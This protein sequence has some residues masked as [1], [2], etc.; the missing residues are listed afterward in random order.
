MKIRKLILLA[1][2]LVPFIAGCSAFFQP[3]QLTSIAPT[4]QTIDLENASG[5]TAYW[6]V[7]GEGN[8]TFDPGDGCDPITIAVDGNTQVSYDYTKGGVYDVQ[9]VQ[10]RN[11]YQAQVVIAVDEPVV[12]KPFYLKTI[13]GK[14]ERISFNVVGRDVGCDS[15]TGY[16]Q[17]ET[18]ISPG[19]GTTEWRMTAYDQDGVRVALFDSGENNI[20]GQW[21]DLVKDLRETQMVSCWADWYLDTPMGP[22]A[23]AMSCGDTDPWIPPTPEKD[24]GWIAFKLEARN[25]FM[26]EPYPSATWIIFVEQASGCS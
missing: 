12:R 2:F 26:N 1:V 18:G 24:D 22:V 16:P 6:Q 3:E 7:D 10:G 8:F 13:V 15:A 5:V 17:Y 23:Q 9:F 25:E 20:W 14:R 21:V 4:T 11:V 19:G